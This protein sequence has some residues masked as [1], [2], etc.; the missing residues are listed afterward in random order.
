M[1][2]D[3]LRAEWFW[4]DRWTSS[5]GGMLPMEARGLY[6][7]LLS[8]AWIRGGKLPFDSEELCL[9]A[10][11]RQSEWKRCWP[12]VEPHWVVE[13]GSMWNETQL[14][15]I[16]KGNEIRA[17]RSKAGSKGGSKTQANRRAKA[18]ANAQAKSK[19]LDLSPSPDQEQSQSLEEQISVST[20]PHSAKA[21]NGVV[22]RVFDQWV[23]IMGKN[24]KQAKLTPKRKRLVEA[25]LAEGYTEQM[26]LEAI[27][28]CKDSPH[29]QGDN[30]RNQ[31]YNSLDL[32]CRDGEHVEQFLC[33][34][35]TPAPVKIKPGTSQ[36]AADL[37]DKAC[38]SEFGG[39]ER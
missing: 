33:E 12:L 14:K 37:V 5:T 18:K 20:K 19:P 6:R 28:G 21:E 27:Q 36:Y 25:R 11:C 7:E 31:V 38:Q 23:S 35:A 29:H 26:L 9:I 8:Q 3:K 4:V 17:F 10:R 30:D 34:K 32:I 1:A 13:D 15:I 24:P 16:Q 22:K 2:K 39:L